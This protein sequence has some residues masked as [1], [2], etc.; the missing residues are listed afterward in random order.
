MFCDRELVPE[1]DAEHQIVNLFVE[2][3]PTE[4]ILHGLNPQ[5]FL[6]GF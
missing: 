2:K 5:M 4:V 1:L 3:P 6:F